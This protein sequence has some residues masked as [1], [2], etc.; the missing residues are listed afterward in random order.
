MFGESFDRTNS[1]GQSNQLLLLIWQSLDDKSSVSNKVANLCEISSDLAVHYLLGQLVDGNLMVKENES[2]LVTWGVS[3]VLSPMLVAR[4]ASVVGEKI[5]HGEIT[6][7][8][9]TNAVKLSTAESGCAVFTSVRDRN[10]IHHLRTEVFVE[11]RNNS[12]ELM[13]V[14]AFTGSDDIINYFHI[15]GI[16]HV[17]LLIYQESSNKCSCD[18]DNISVSVLQLL[19]QS[20]ITLAKSYDVDAV[21]RERPAKRRKMSISPKNSL[22]DQLDY[23]CGLCCFINEIIQS[24]PKVALENLNAD[25]LARCDEEIKSAVTLR[26][27]N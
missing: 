8:P 9:Q 17:C 1:S 6:F 16:V 19:I 13:Q 11:L 18:D 26:I 5:F 2:V 23:L 24:L 21:T 25:I 15:F 14:L 10:L 20:H 22:D 4:L 12:R 27:M 3:T 7:F